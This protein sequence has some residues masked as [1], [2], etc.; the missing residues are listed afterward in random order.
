VGWA[1]LAA[2]AAG[3]ARAFR[4]HDLRHG[5]WPCRSWRLARGARCDR[6]G[7]GAKPTHGGLR[8]DRSAARRERARRELAATGKRFVSV[9]F[10]QR[11]RIRAIVRTLSRAIAQRMRRQA[12]ASFMLRTCASDKAVFQVFPRQNAVAA[13]RS[14]RSVASARMHRPRFLAPLFVR[15][16]HSFLP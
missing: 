1:Q 2:D 5:G 16:F 15:S 14:A 9:P 12:R 8:A 13:R 10:K 6:A 11:A 4:R 7:S 3:A